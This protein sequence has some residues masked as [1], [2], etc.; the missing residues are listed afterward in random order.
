MISAEDKLL[1]GGFAL[2]QGEL[3]AVGLLDKKGKPVK[4]KELNPQPSYEDIRLVDL[5]K[6]VGMRTKP[7][8]P[9]AKEVSKII[10]LLPK[11]ELYCNITL[12]AIY[13]LMEWSARVLPILHTGF[14][15]V[16]DMI[17]AEVEKKSG[18][19]T[20]KNSYRVA[21]NII[22]AIDGRPMLEKEIR[23]K[24]VKTWAKNNKK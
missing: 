6:Q 12:V 11:D 18:I 19:E 5:Y 13:L 1:H 16:G 4:R 10:D 14:T 21:D 22:R 2:L 23:D 9:G 24:W 3:I 8:L 7:G 15:S 17:K 20:R